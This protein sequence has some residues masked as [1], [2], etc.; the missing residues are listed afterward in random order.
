MESSKRKVYTTAR[1]GI[2]ATVIL[3]RRED[4]STDIDV[5]VEIDEHSGKFRKT[6]PNLVSAE[7][8]T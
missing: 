7:S 1:D 3:S 4:G 6:L 5:S 8:E 2:K